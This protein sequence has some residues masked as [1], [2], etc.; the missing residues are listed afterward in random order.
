MLRLVLGSSIFS[1]RHTNSVTDLISRQK[2]ACLGILTENLLNKTPCLKNECRSTLISLN[3]SFTLD[4]SVF[5]L[6]EVAVG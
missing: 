2:H 4:T 1:I 5:L 3:I 6:K